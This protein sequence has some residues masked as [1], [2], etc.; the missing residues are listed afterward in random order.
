MKLYMK[1]V[2]TKMKKILTKLFFILF[3]LYEYYKSYIIKYRIKEI[4]ETM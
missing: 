4:Y 2:N 3:L 1:I